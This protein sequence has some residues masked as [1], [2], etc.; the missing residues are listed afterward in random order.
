MKLCCACLHS[1]QF[2]TL[3]ATRKGIFRVFDLPFRYR[4]APLGLKK[5]VFKVFKASIF[6]ALVLLMS[7]N[8]NNLNFVEL[9]W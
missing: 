2:S 7:Y 4:C 3:I 5:K 6:T 9:Y 1:S 8:T